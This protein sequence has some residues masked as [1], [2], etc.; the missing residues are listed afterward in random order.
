MLESM[1][2]V[3]SH[4]EAAEINKKQAFQ[5]FWSLATRPTVNIVVVQTDTTT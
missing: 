4:Y 3:Q 1:S 5:C 2:L